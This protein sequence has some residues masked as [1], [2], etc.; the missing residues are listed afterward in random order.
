MSDNPYSAPEVAGQRINAPGAKRI[1]KR[2]N[3]LQLGKLLGVLYALMGLLFAPFILI[4][5][6]A[7]GTRGAGMGVGFALAAPIIY[8]VLGFIGGLIA[9]LLYN[10][11]AKFVGGIEVEIE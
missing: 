11:V 4:A 5:G 6:A 3:A 9:A 1:V 2:F 8:G 7:G 10:L